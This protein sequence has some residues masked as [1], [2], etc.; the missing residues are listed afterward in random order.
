MKNI[1]ILVGALLVGFG[2]YR[3]V[4]NYYW[5][6]KDEKM[7]LDF[8]VKNQKGQGLSAVANM[9]SIEDVCKCVVEIAKLDLKKKDYINFIKGEFADSTYDNSYK[10]EIR[11]AKALNEFYTQCLN[12]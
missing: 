7:A 3:Y 9:D 6:E 5:S 11:M 2:V 4:D 10:A 1:L 8:C 12:K